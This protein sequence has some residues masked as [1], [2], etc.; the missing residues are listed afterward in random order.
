MFLPRICHQTETLP[1]F[2]WEMW[3]KLKAR[4]PLPAVT[5]K[6]S[7]Q[8]LLWRS[9][10]PWRFSAESLWCSQVKT[11]GLLKVYF[12]PPAGRSLCV[13]LTSGLFSRSYFWFP[14]WHSSLRSLAWWLAAE[15]T[16]LKLLEYRT[17]EGLLWWFQ[18]RQFPVSGVHFRAMVPKTQRNQ[19]QTSQRKITLRGL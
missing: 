5:L 19:N 15:D 4:A 16:H 14:F 10:G 18:A 7:P 17:L 11:S 6:F 13:R 12:R 1:E 3:S 2:H 9:T 8:L